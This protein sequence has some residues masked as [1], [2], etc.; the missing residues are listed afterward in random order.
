MTKTCKMCGKTF[1]TQEELM[2]HAK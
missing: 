2:E 1:P